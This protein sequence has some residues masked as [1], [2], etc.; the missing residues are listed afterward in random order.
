MTER[1]LVNKKEHIELIEKLQKLGAT[2]N[3]PRCGNDSYDVP[4]TYGE[5]TTRPR[6]NEASTGKRIISYVILICDKCG[7]IAQHAITALG[8]PS[9]EPKYDE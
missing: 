2:K 7:Y 9:E 1:F 4:N 5:I 3:C 6:L 8:Y